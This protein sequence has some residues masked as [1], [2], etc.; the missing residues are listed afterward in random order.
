MT[1]DMLTLDLLDKIRIDPL[2]PRHPRSMVINL[3]GRFVEG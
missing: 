3:V 1:V 2:N